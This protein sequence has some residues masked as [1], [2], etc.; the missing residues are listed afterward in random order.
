ME[1]MD[2]FRTLQTRRAFLE[3]STLGVRQRTDI[4]SDVNSSKERCHSRYHVLP[5]NGGD[6]KT[7]GH[8]KDCEHGFHIHQ[9]GDVRAADG[10]SAGGHLEVSTLEPV[11]SDRF[12]LR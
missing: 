4:G 9:F 12:C 1:P 7:P 6:E 8:T 2:E 11:T 10:T 3:R 5:V